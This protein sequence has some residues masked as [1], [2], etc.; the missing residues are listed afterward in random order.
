[1]TDG[2]RV[3]DAALIGLLTEAACSVVGL[4]GHSY[5]EMLDDLYVT[6]HL[7]GV[8][9]LTLFGR[10]GPPASSLRSNLVLLFVTQWAV[11]TGC[12]LAWQFFR[13]RSRSSGEDQVNAAPE[14]GEV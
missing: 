3:S 1:M 2:K 6:I 13:K 4:I 10:H 8:M 12:I 7:P 5:S 11:Y 14:S 9:I